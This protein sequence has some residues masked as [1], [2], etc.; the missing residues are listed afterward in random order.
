MARRPHNFTVVGVRGT[1]YTVHALGE[2]RKYW[3]DKALKVKNEKFDQAH[4]G[5]ILTAKDSRHAGHGRAIKDFAGMVEEYLSRFAHEQSIELAIVP[6]HEAGKVSPALEK[7]AAQLCKNKRFG[8]RSGSLTR[9]KTIPKLAIG[10][11]R[12]LAVHYNSVKFTASNRS[13]WPVLVIDD[14]ST[15][16]NS[17]AACADLVQESG[18]VVVGGLV[19]G[20]TVHD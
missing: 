12:S 10:G 7:V 9:T 19:L 13:R 16:G 15:T 14:V 2:Y 17:L 20:R 18:V 8:Y 5:L 3:I 1:T 6:S 4:S 11:D